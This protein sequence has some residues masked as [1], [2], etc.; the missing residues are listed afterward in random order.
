MKRSKVG[1]RKWIAAVVAILSGT[2]APSVRRLAGQIQVNKM[3]AA[4]M[5]KKI[6]WAL[7]HDRNRLYAVLEAGQAT[8]NQQKQDHA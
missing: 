3:T 5:I 1:P 8:L 4:S 6:D 7:V 2:E